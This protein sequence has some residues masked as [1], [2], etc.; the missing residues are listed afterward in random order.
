MQGDVRRNVPS[1]NGVEYPYH[2]PLSIDLADQEALPYLVFYVRDDN[3]AAYAFELPTEE[4]WD[5]PETVRKPRRVPD[6][7]DGAD[8]QNKQAQ[9][10]QKSDSPTA[11]ISEVASATNGAARPN[12][13]QPHLYPE[14]DAMDGDDVVMSDVEEDG[15]RTPIRINNALDATT[16]GITVERREYRDQPESR[17]ATHPI[18]VNFFSGE[19]YQGSALK[20]RKLYHGEGHLIYTNGDEYK[21]SFAHGLPS[22]KGTM[23]Y[24][25]SGNTYD[26]DWIEGKHHGQGTY[27]ELAT[28][29]VFEGGWKEGKRSGSFVL[30][31]TVTDEDKGLCQICYTRDMTTAFYECGH[32]LACRDCAMQVESCPICRK[33]V[34]A[35]LELYGVKVSME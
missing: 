19:Y 21:G 17:E 7:F 10:L 15:S 24:A 30:R 18:T 13:G 2:R 22:G 35:R 29:N 23:I 20:H 16:N 34:L 6:S 11:D 1:R 25:A 28:G 3:D 31:G 12:G 33:R 32:V 5:I 27:K 8:F 14:H 4:R 9:A 26:G